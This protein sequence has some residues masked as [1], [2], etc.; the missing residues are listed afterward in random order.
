LIPKNV[1]IL[2]SGCF[3]SCESLLSIR[4]ESYSRLTR[5]E[6]EAFYESS[7]RSVLI[8]SNVEILGL[9]SFSLCNS[10]WSI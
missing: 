3:S 5:I 9:K 1:E 4:F 10:L 8:P 6:S 2:G 7:L